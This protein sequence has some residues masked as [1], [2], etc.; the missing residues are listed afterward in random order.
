MAT[1]VANDHFAAITHERVD[2]LVVLF[3]AV[4]GTNRKE[5]G[6]LA[7]NARFPAIYQISEF[8][9]LGGLMSYGVGAD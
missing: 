8:V 1:A 5:I 9:G 3:D 4:T 6:E 2:G 7:A